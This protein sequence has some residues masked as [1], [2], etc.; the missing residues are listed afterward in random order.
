MAIIWTRVNTA[1]LLLVLFAL[2]ALVAMFA[3][4]A[5]GGPLDPPGSPGST[6]GVRQP[7]TPISGPT[8]ITT[9]GHYYLTRNISV[10]GPQTAITISTSDVTLDLGGF[11][12]AGDDNSGSIGVSVSGAFK[13]I[14]IRNGV[15]RDF[16]IGF[17]VDA[18]NYVQLIDV[19]ADSNLVGVE[20][21]LLSIISGCVVSDNTTGIS[22]LLDHSA[23][24]DCMVVENTGRG[25]YTEFAATIWNSVVKINGTDLERKIP[26]VGYVVIFDTRYCTNTGPGYVLYGGH[27]DCEGF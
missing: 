19:T 8:T 12:I 21:G 17:N 14:A 11:T 1:L 2:L 9:P 7:G 5:R 20:L 16:L 10:T 25:V 6:D 23:I 24:Q 4:D 26:A 15:V 3:A 18:A 27:D 22:V 13:N